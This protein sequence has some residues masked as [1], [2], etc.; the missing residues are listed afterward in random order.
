MME[1]VVAKGQRWRWLQMLVLL[2]LAVCCL[3]GFVPPA[4]AGII[5][6]PLVLPDA[7][8]ALAAFLDKIPDRY[9]GGWLALDKPIAPVL[10]GRETV[11][12][13]FGPG[14]LVELLPP[15]AIWDSAPAGGLSALDRLLLGWALRLPPYPEGPV[16]LPLHERMLLVPSRLRIELMPRAE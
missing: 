3:C 16:R 14:V 9:G 1:R 4:G 13:P 7:E 8:R 2:P 11:L 6:E 12:F 10:L 5:M 15:D